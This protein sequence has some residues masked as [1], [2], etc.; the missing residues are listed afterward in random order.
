MGDEEI[1]W[2][3]I[4]VDQVE[5]V[6]AAL[7][8]VARGLHDEAA[9]LDDPVLRE[10][11]RARISRLVRTMKVLQ[12]S[13][14]GGRDKAASSVGEHESRFG[15][16]YPQGVGAKQRQGLIMPGGIGETGFRPIKEPAAGCL[17]V[18]QDAP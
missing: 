9:S 2:L 14:N 10:A 13:A 18:A 3:R 1:V 4:P 11:I 15:L 17:V 12:E 7:Y 16:S 5:E 6:V 8:G